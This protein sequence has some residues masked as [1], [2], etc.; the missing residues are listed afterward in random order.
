[1]LSLTGPLTLPEDVLLIPVT[2]LPDETREQLDCD[3]ADVAVSRLQGRT[4][5]RIVDADAADLLARFREPRTLV[6]AVIL[7]GRARELDP[8]EVLEGAYPFLRGMVESGFLVPAG[9]E[10]DEPDG[11]RRGAPRFPAGSE[12]LGGRVERTLQVLEDTEVALLASAEGRSVLKIERP[13][14]GAGARLL[15]E[16]FQREAAFLA[17]LNGAGAPALLRQGEVEDRAFLE[18]AFC[19]GVDAATAAA[20]WRE[21]GPEGREELLALCRRIAR[22]YTDLHGRGVLHGDVH[23]RNVLIDSDGAVWLLDFGVARAV[24]AAHGLPAAADR[25]GIPF[26]YEPEFAAAQLAGSPPPPATEAGEQH[27]VAALLYF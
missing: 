16:R 14:R 26:F 8:D 25:G 20:E 11:P 12:L 19:P 5:S 17:H 10:T 2:D 24:D 1:M 3:P 13:L 18:M 4:G 15:A 9:S 22:S 21:R 27:A 6:E 23:P 7:F